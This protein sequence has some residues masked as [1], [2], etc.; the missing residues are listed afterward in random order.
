MKNIGIERVTKGRRIAILVMVFCMILSVSSFAF[1]AEAS[2]GALFD[3]VTEMVGEIFDELVTISTLIAA[4]GITI[5]FFIRLLSRN[6]RAVEEANAWIKRIIIS[7]LV[8]NA[9]S[10][11][12]AYGQSIVDTL[13]EGHQGNIY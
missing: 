4:L 6:Q 5:A 10:F 11:F 1:A 7:W 13:N 2:T 12:V 9:L 8:I 3:T